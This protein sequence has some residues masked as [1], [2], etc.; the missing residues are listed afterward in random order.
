M[1]FDPTTLRQVFEKTNGLCHICRK[2]L[3]FANYGKSDRRGRWQ[4]E[5]SVPQAKGGTHHLN[6]LF[7]ACP[8]CNQAKGVLPTR[9]ARSR[10]GNKA[11]PLSKTKVKSV[12]TGNSTFGMIIGGALGLIAGPVGMGI[13]AL[14]GYSLGKDAN[15]QPN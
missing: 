12:R 6:N 4:V 11:A 1:A 8:D 14:L 7:A 13:G 3:A 10:H 5:H 9:T 2:T 15:V